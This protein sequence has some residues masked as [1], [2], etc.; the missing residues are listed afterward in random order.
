MRRLVHKLRPD[1]EIAQ[2][3]SAE[4]ALDRIALSPPDILMTDI[5]ME[6]MDGLTMI[7]RVRALHPNMRIVIV[8][9]YDMFQYALR[10]IRVDVV[11]Y[12]LKPVDEADLVSLLQRIEGGAPVDPAPQPDCT[13]AS[14][15]VQKALEI[16]ELRYHEDIS[17]D[18]V[19]NGLH[20]NPAYLSTLLKREAGV[21]FAQYLKD[22][23][24]SKSKKL[25]RE[26]RLKVQEICLRVG[27]RDAGYFSRVFR[28]EYGVSPEEYRRRPKS[29]G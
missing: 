27:Y 16:I 4:A 9:A 3:E 7:E 15:P 21:G 5:R 20:M 23:R 22:V 8:S 25:L 2:A 29:D 19:A 17:L 24:L 14:E 1:Y 28:Q 18:V 12:L 13:S 10:A 26:T 6:H 11:D